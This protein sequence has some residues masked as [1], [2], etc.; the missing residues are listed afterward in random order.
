MDSKNYVM[1]FDAIKDNE[2]N[3]SQDFLD[4]VLLP[5]ENVDCLTDTEDI[6]DSNLDLID[7]IS[8]FPETSGNIEVFFEPTEIQNLDSD[9]L[10]ENETHIPQNKLIN[11]ETSEKNLLH[12]EDKLKEL[13]DKNLSSYEIFLELFDENLF[14]HIV[15]QS[16]IYAHQ[17]NNHDFHLTVRDLKSFIGILIL[18]GYHRLPRQYMYWESASDS[19]VTLIKNSMSYKKFKLIKKFIHFNDNLKVDINDKVF[20]VQPLVKALNKN[21]MKFGIFDKNIS[22]DEQM[23]PY[24]G[25]HSAKMFMKNKPIRFGFKK[26]IMAS[27]SGYVYNFKIYTGKSDNYNR[28]LGLGGSVVT[29]FANNVESLSNINFYFDNFFTSYK[30]MVELKNKGINATG[31]VRQNRIKKCPMILP[32]LM[33]KKSRGEYEVYREKN[34]NIY[35][36]Q[37]NDTKPV[38]IMSNCYNAF[39]LKNVK[40]YIK[41][42][43]KYISVN[44]PFIIY[45]YNKFMGGVDLADNLISCYRINIKGKKWYWPLFTNMISLAV[46]NSLKI[47][48]IINNTKIDLLEHTRNIVTGLITAN[49]QTKFVRKSILGRIQDSNMCNQPIIVS[50]PEKRRRRCVECKSTTIYICKGCLNHL[51]IKCSSKYHKI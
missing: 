21:F 42:E 2:I 24:R 18:S 39:P 15:K 41:T 20:K 19:G 27:S 7:D 40:R 23:V 5:P 1:L 12:C 48:N 33:S 44:Q 45:K 34:L 9:I 38:T 4:F 17:S 10:W 51:H 14:T 22:I 50:D 35:C 6:V 11:I 13:F 30:L 43:K 36:I 16:N 31:T 25:R 49:N 46:I 28:E 3:N 32:K 37:W 26:W 47:Y 29:E 8:L